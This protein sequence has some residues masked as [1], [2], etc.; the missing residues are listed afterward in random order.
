MSI[1][2]DLS[3]DYDNFDNE[4]LSNAYRNAI[5]RSMEIDRKIEGCFIAHQPALLAEFLHDQMRLHCFTDD[6]L[7][8]FLATIDQLIN[9]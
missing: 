7:R 9:R 4:E 1:Q 5:E 6:E 8:L 2:I 3:K